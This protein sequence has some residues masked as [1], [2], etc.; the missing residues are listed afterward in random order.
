MNYRPAFLIVLTMLLVAVA[1]AALPEAKPK[2]GDSKELSQARL[3]LSNMVGPLA[4]NHPAVREQIQKVRDLE[5]TK[6]K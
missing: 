4:T 5:R 1:Y 6:K 2:P 3:R